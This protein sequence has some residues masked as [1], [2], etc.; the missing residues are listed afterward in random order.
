M[1]I[2]L[3]SVFLCIACG[4]KDDVEWSQ[5]NGDEDF[6]EVV[7]TES[8]EIVEIDGCDSGVSCTDLHSRI[9]GATIGT[10][11]VDPASGPVGTLH[12]ILAVVGDD[13]ED[14]IG[15]VSLRVEGD[16]GEET[17]DLEQD[18]ANAGAW[19][20]TLESVGFSGKIDEE[21]VDTFTFLLFEADVVSGSKDEEPE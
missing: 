2:A 13:W 15:L 10:A 21:R 16:R 5:F 4:G 11:T 1:R 17:Y 8:E 6:V 20:M 9:E 14:Q 3:L 19:G 7:I 18:R 12:K